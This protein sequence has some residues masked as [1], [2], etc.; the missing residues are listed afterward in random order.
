MIRIGLWHCARQSFQRRITFS[1]RTSSGI[2]KEVGGDRSFLSEGDLQKRSK[3]TRN[4]PTSKCVLF[5]ALFNICRVNMIQKVILFYQTP[6]TAH[7]ILFADR[8]PC[9]TTLSGS[10]D[11]LHP[12]SCSNLQTPSS[13]HLG[14]IISISVLIASLFRQW[15]DFCFYLQLRIIYSVTSQLLLSFGAL[16]LFWRNP[17]VSII[18]LYTHLILVC[19]S[20]SCIPILKCL[21]ENEGTSFCD[22]L[23]GSPSL[24]SSRGAFEQSS[25][26]CVTV[27]NPFA[28]AD[29]QTFT[30]MWVCSRKI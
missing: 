20:D 2:G 9:D 16:D 1:T 15:L 13:T 5:A 14:K 30:T 26:S 17:T 4:G 11:Q 6:F 18:L 3:V 23:I 24:T 28:F 25:P 27:D 10:T 29:R 22:N 8:G 21:Q 7:F 19:S 12:P